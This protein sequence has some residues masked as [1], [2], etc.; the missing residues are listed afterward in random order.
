M[1]SGEQTSPIKIAII[2]FDGCMTTAVAGLIDSLTIANLWAARIKSAPEGA[3][4]SSV[5]SASTGP[6]RG[7]GGFSIPTAPLSGAPPADI[8]IV[9]PIMGPIAETLLANGSI[10]ARLRER[11]TEVIASVCTGA[12]F[13]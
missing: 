9:P 2:A 1:R 11:R 6:V 8:L 12:F 10:V 7:S 5:L 13:L 3:F 4:V